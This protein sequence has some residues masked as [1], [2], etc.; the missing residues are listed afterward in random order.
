MG[1]GT[2]EVCFTA[3]E[4]E[5]DFSRS[6]HQQMTQRGSGSDRLRFLAGQRNDRSQQNVA[7]SGVALLMRVPV[8]S[9]HTSE[10]ASGGQLENDSLTKGPAPECR[11]IE[12]PGPVNGQTFVWICPI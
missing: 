5:R 6:I 11:S 7:L 4:V 9:N 12:I 8:R 1:C 3:S 2:L 10:P